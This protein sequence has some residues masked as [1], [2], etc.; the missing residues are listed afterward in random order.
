MDAHRVPHQRLHF[1]T[2]ALLLLGNVQGCADSPATPETTI[3]GRIVIIGGNDQSGDAGVPLPAPLQVRVED[4]EGRPLSGAAISW[5]VRSGG[6]ALAGT[7][8][9]DSRGI[10]EAE[11]SPGATVITQAATAQ[12]PNVDAVWFSSSVDVSR[13]ELEIDTM[14]AWPDDSGTLGYSVRDSGGRWLEGAF[15]SWS[16]SNP[17]AFEVQEGGNFLAKRAGTAE[18]IASFANVA[19]TASVRI[20]QRVTGR[21]RRLRP[22]EGALPTDLIVAVDGVRHQ[23]SVAADGTFSLRLGNPVQDRRAEIIVQADDGAAYFPI[24]IPVDTMQMADSVPVLIIPRVWEIGDGSFAG[25][26][27]ALSLND[28]VSIP[29]GVSHPY[30]RGEVT[31]L[32][33][34]ITW[35]D[36]GQLPIVLEISREIS[37]SW[38]FNMTRDS[39]ALWQTLNAIEVVVG[40]DLFEPF[41]PESGDAPDVRVGVRF[42]SNAWKRSGTIS[43]SG[44]SFDVAGW[45]NGTAVS[46]RETAVDLGASDLTVNSAN[47]LKNLAVWERLTLVLLGMEADLTRRPGWCLFRS[48]NADCPLFTSSVFTEADVA[49]L[50]LS[51]AV[52]TVFRDL[53]FA[54][55]NARTPIGLASVFGERALWLGREPVPVRSGSLGR[56]DA[57]RPSLP[58]RQ[59]HGI[60]MAEGNLGFVRTRPVSCAHSDTLAL[61][62]LSA[63]GSRGGRG[64]SRR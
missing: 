48:I 29:L 40:L 32:G 64:C 10:A 4:S 56:A 31:A 63:Q 59:T 26:R 34:D 7:T 51:L 46:S 33:N 27:P 60:P 14:R 38:M 53:R 58:D 5:Q 2:L 52:G 8:V 62:P 49:A 25:T 9:T 15:V 41:S 43:V 42:I 44:R 19:D 22:G 12:A 21:V 16:S 13:L 23:L 45:R 54:P 37:D 6:G 1:W 57:P 35:A 20:L 18:V 28:L 36:G 24:L 39:T 55:R 11:W 30:W 17:A 61:P 47:T 3:I 50:Q